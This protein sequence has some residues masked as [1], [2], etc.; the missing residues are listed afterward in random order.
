MLT[1]KNE[2][3]ELSGPEKILRDK[4][5]EL[6]ESVDCIE[7]IN[8]ATIKEL[9]VGMYTQQLVCWYGYYRYLCRYIC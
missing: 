2:N 9:V 7:K 8:L 5:N 3:Y 4:M 6:S 1:V